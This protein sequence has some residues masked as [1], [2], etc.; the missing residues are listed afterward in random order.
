MYF[1]YSNQIQSMKIRYFRTAGLVLSCVLAAATALSCQKPD[2]PNDTD[3]PGTPDK[4]ESTSLI[5]SVNIHMS[6]YEGSY[7]YEF[8]Y[9]DQNR[10]SKILR[11]NV[12]DESGQISDDSINIDVSYQ[13]GSISLIYHFSDGEQRQILAEV[14][15]NGRAVRTDNDYEGPVTMTYDASGMLSAIEADYDY[16]DGSNLITFT[17]ENG[18]TTSLSLDGVPCFKFYYTDKAAANVNLNLNWMLTL[19]HGCF[20][21]WGIQWLGVLGMLGEGDTHY[22]LPMYWVDQSPAGM[23]GGEIDESMLDEPVIIDEFS[24]S[25]WYEY[26]DDNAGYECSVTDDGR[27]VSM[28]AKIPVYNVTFKLTGEYEVDPEDYD[29]DTHTYS[30]SW[31]NITDKE[32]LSR[33]FL[34][35][36]CYEVTIVYY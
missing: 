7:Y 22:A 5:K 26:E 15:G 30:S 4:P 25:G 12:D 28:T 34:D 6:E 8:G 27:L 18:N 32:E 36:A 21:D 20:L 31:I 33:T 23:G 3:E 1:I 13:D 11:S 9:D 24:V 17:R 2:D 10:V 14:D 16:Y 19:G 35:Y 29:P